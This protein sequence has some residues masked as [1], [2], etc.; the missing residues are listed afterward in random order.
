MNNLITAVSEVNDFM[1]SKGWTYCLIRGLAVQHWGEPRTTL[2]ADFTLITGWGQEA[3]YIDTL[4]S[5][6]E[7]RI[8][9][10]RQIALTHRI[11]LVHASNG[12]PVDIALGAI[13]FE[14]EMMNRATHIDLA[15]GC[16]VPCCTAEDLFIMKAFAGRPKDW[17]DAESI[18]ARQP[19]LDVNYIRQHLSDLCSAKKDTLTLQK[20]LALLGAA[21]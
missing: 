2:D 12:V 18:L 6:F 8:P 14:I 17:G 10:A 13:P 4:L 3:P 15:P 21:S 7:S 5:Q 1:A 20:A 9:D 16:S 19:Q 11:L